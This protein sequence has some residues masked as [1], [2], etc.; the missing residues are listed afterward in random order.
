MTETYF[1]LFLIAIFCFVVF[2]IYAYSR[3]E[4]IL[5]Y[6]SDSMNR[7]GF[8]SEG[9][10]GADLS[11]RAGM[12]GLTAP[13]EH[14]SF[15]SPASPPSPQPPPAPLTDEEKRR[16]TGNTVNSVLGK[17]VRAAGTSQ[18]DINFTVLDVH[19]YTSGGVIWFQLE[20]EHYLLEDED[21]G[22]SLFIEPVSPE[23]LELTQWRLDSI[24]EDKSGA[25]VYN[26]IQFAYITDGSAVFEENGQ[27]ARRMNFWLFEDPQRRY[28]IRIEE[29]EK[30]LSTGWF[31]EYL[32]AGKVSF[33]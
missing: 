22:F 30:G 13:E 17:T 10:D 3:D 20:G 2:V 19:R 9:S 25:V 14:A 7:P 16:L 27:R 28:F 6:P 12:S 11:P 24:R 4:E 23:S 18:G 5:T 33:S 31:G 29:D 8:L 26:N 15:L 32:E 21:S 1:L